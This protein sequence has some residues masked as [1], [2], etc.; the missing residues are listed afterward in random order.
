MRKNTMKLIKETKGTVNPM[1]DASA[2]DLNEIRDNS[3]DMCELAFNCFIFGYAQGMK[4]AV[5]DT[6]K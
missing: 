2:E 3:N 1:Y 4:A 5:A 6:R